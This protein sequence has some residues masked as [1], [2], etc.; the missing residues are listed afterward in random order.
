MP[1]EASIPPPAGFDDLH[2]HERR[3]AAALLDDLRAGRAGGR[4]PPGSHPVVTTQA[5]RLWVNTGIAFYLKD[6]VAASADSQVYLQ[7]D[8]RLLA[9][10]EAWQR[11]ALISP[12]GWDGTVYLGIVQARADRYHPERAGDRLAE[13]LD[14]LADRPLKAD[15]LVVLADSHFEGGRAI[16]AQG[17]YVRSFDAFHLPAYINFRAQKGVGGQ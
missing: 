2:D 6:P 16:P 4:E 5:A 12:G 10:R 13:L 15:L 11:A 8:R 7:T 9:A 1:W 3:E 14:R 17:Y